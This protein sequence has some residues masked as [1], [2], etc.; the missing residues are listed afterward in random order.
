M[1]LDM[2]FFRIRN[3]RVPK[4]KAEQVS[5]VLQKLS[6]DEHEEK[7]QEL[8]YWRKVN[9]IHSWFVDHVQDGQD[10][11]NQ[12]IVTKEKAQELMDTCKDVLKNKTM[13]EN[14]L[15]TQSG[16]FFGDTDYD[17]YYFKEL[18]RTV[19]TLKHVIKNWD[20]TNYRYYY[21]SSW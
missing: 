18:K 11:C 4:T 9:A 10:N 1:G 2:F 13:A 15:P 16:F 12:Y 3:K 6:D 7:H 20:S 5:K 21:Q 8:M 19:N 14:L 17:P